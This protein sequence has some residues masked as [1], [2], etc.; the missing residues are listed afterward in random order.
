ML[1]LVYIFKMAANYILYNW[2][3]NRKIYI[4]VC[5]RS[6]IQYDNLYNHIHSDYEY[7]ACDKFKWFLLY[8]NSY[9]P[10][11]YDI[12]S[13]ADIQRIQGIQEKIQ[14]T[15]RIYEMSFCNQFQPP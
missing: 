14:N 10:N 3:K 4:P 2:N 15:T 12:D 13:T 1:F 8:S 7:T 9:E 6:L 5:E 11:K